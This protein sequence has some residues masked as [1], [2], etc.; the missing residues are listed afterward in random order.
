MTKCPWGEVMGEINYLLYV[1]EKMQNEEPLTPIARMIDEA[2]GRYKYDTQEAR[3]IMRRIE[4]LK[5]L[6]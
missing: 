5:K 6:L 4:K 2:T 1:L 3:K